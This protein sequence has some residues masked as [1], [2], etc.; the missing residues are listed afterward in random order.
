MPLG[1]LFVLQ[2]SRSKSEEQQEAEDQVRAYSIS[3]A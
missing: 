1:Y 3:S 2:T